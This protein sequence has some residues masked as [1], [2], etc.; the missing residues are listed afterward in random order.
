MASI[1]FA[2]DAKSTLAGTLSNV[3]LSLNL[4]TGTGALFPSPTGG[5][6]FMMTLIDAATGLIKEILKVTARTG[7]TC[8]IVRAQE[9]TGA[10]TWAAGSLAINLNTAGTMGTIEAQSLVASNS[11]P[12]SGGAMTGPVTSSSTFTAAGFI[13]PLTGNV[14]GNTS[15]SSGSCTGNAATASVAATATTASGLVTA[16]TIAMTGDVTWSLS[17][18]GTANVSA[19]GAIANNAVTF[20]KMQ[21]IA[22]LSVLGNVAGFTNT[23][24]ALS[25]ATLAA[26]LGSSAPVGGGANTFT[27]GLE[28]RT[29]NGSTSGPGT[30]V[31]F[32]VPFTT[33][34]LCVLAGESSASS[35]WNTNN[36]TFYAA[37]DWNVNQFG[38]VCFKWNGIGIIPQGGVSGFNYIAIGY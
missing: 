23:P 33:A 31:F 24:T 37:Q 29:G 26:I 9:G 21:Q 30:T 15:G 11:L 4:A 17:F 36:V 12:L 3:G 19:A 2:N 5:D 1:L 25:M 13:G 32:T 16:R 34:C 28:I 27:N 8:T 10:Q 7:D 35:G 20:A 14:T 38:L 22:N 6:Y 18:Q